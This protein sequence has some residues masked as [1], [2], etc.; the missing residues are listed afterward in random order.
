MIINHLYYYY[1]KYN[2]LKI[3][4]IINE[5]NDDFGTLKLILILYMC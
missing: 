2:K 5:S 3:Y 1:N 4:T